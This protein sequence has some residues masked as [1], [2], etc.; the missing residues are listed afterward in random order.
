MWTF[1][2]WTF[3]TPFKKKNS[4]YNI[5]IKPKT[6]FMFL[7]LLSCLETGKISI[8]QR[9]ININL[10]SGSFYYTFNSIS[11]LE[12]RSS[13][14]KTI[15]ST[16]RPQQAHSIMQPQ[17]GWRNR[18]LF[19]VKN[20]IKYY[21]SMTYDLN[22]MCLPTWILRFADI[23]SWY[24]TNITWNSMKLVIINKPAKN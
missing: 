12:Q 24:F 20:S 6:L 9:N 10:C 21:P 22:N 8:P 5:Y 7:T 13:S 19:F 17:Y 16:D 18:V 14:S 2:I 11:K 15:V 3:C 23:L 1:G 4:K